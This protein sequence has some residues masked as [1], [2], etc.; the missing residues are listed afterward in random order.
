M[1]ENGFT[2]FLTR[3]LKCPWF[4]RAGKSTCVVFGATIQQ[5][6][7]RSVFRQ[8]LKPEKAEKIAVSPQRFAKIIDEM[9]CRLLVK[10]NSLDDNLHG[11]SL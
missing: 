2:V 10:K 9:S 4:N 8:N 6:L 7:L 1:D 11:H 3:W 5:H